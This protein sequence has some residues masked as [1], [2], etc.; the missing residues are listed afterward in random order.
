[1]V[2][3]DGRAGKLVK[4]WPVLPYMALGVWFASMRILSSGAVWLSDNEVDGGNIR[5]LVIVATVAS[6][7]VFFIGAFGASGFRGRVPRRGLATMSGVVAG[8]GA[9]VVIAAGP[10]YFEQFLSWEAT[11]VLFI[12]GGLLMGFGLGVIGLYC[13]QL[14]G[15]LP[16][17]RVVMYVAF[18]ECLVAILFFT[19]IG[20][21]VWKPVA[22]GP[23]LADM[24]FFV[25]LP[26]CAG[27]LVELSAFL[28]P[29]RADAAELR[30]N[31]LP[32]A[33]WKLLTVVFAFS[34][35]VS[36]VYG[37]VVEHGSVELTLDGSRFVML[38]QMVLALLLAGVAQ[39]T[40]GDRLNFGKLYS[41]VMVA[42]VVLVAC[43]PIVSAFQTVLSQIVS[44]SDSK[45]PKVI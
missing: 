24:I 45:A 40:E 10:F 2:D 37:V 9:L 19:V 29:L 25:L 20:S 26:V 22:G 8:L 42:S 1:M 21:P 6:A 33:F 15:A 7:V 18:S 5:T 27:L 38:A 16:P 28:P 3:Y 11:E 31:E 4:A 35:I 36:S 17:G 39:I 32:K 41:V 12:F 43:L 30:E 13:G 34:F 14:Y 23:S 44:L